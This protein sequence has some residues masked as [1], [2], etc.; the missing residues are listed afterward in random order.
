MPSLPPLA[1]CYLERVF[2]ARGASKALNIGTALA[3][4]RAALKQV[5]EEVDQVLAALRGLVDTPPADSTAAAGLNLT[6]EKHWRTLRGMRDVMQEMMRW[7]QPIAA[8][9]SGDSRIFVSGSR[10]AAAFVPRGF[11]DLLGPYRSTVAKHRGDMLAE[12][13]STGWPSSTRPVNEQNLHRCKRCGAEHAKLWLHRQLCF[14]CEEALRADG[15]CPY[16]ERCGRRSFCP[17]GRRCV[18]CEAW[19][20]EACRLLRGDS[21]DVW[22]LVG[23]LK[24]AVV[25]MDFDRTLATTKAGGSPL[26]G[27]HSVDPELAAICASHNHVQ[28]VTRSSQKEDIEKFLADKAVP[29]Q[30]VRSLRREGKR[31]K[32][33]VILEELSLLD[34]P[35]GTGLFVDDDIRELTEPALQPAV[36]A[37]QLL[38]FLF[39][40]AEIAKS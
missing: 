28:V 34:P 27:N 33:Q 18:V 40:R 24:P 9:R 32:A 11:A 2:I 5:S 8:A 39:V 19:S 36:E 4:Y 15:C 31:D 13:A 16:S 26:Q 12:I 22:Q 20:C 6:A 1:R 21:E 14:S 30:C 17:H 23:Q 37:G 3:R 29:V 7:L 35:G 25:F 10:G 38:R